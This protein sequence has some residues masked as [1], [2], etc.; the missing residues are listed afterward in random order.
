MSS[1]FRNNKRC[2]YSY[3]NNSPSISFLSAD[4]FSFFEKT[5]AVAICVW[6]IILQS[7]SKLLMSS[8]FRNVKRCCYSYLN[9]SPTISFQ[10]EDVLPF[11]ETKRFVT[12]CIWIIV[13]QSLFQLLM[14]SPFRNDKRSRFPYLNNGPSISCSTADVLPLYILQALSL[15]VFG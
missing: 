11:F 1:P 4:V 3:L 12:I 9:N 10:N 8:P 2:R 5:I 13:L 7:I 14:S 15:F 6:I